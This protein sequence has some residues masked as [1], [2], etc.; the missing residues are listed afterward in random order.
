MR[1][2][3]DISATELEQ[4][5]T[6]AS[7]HELNTHLLAEDIILGHYCLH[8]KNDDSGVIKRVIDESCD[9]KD[10]PECK[11]THATTREEFAN[12]AKHEVIF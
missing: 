1:S 10:G 3:T 6:T 2:F 11:D 7:E 12:C 4:I 9:D 8:G 5:Y